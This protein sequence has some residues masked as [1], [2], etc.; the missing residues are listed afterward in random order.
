MC[1]IQKLSPE[2]WKISMLYQHVCSLTNNKL[3]CRLCLQSR[4]ETFVGSFIREFHSEEF[5]W[6]VS[7]FQSV[8]EHRCS[9]LVRWV[10][11]DMTVFTGPPHMDKSGVQVGSRPLQHLINDIWGRCN[12]TW[13]GDLITEHCHYEL[14]FTHRLRL[15]WGRNIWLIFL[16]W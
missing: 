15:G 3:N 4:N 11:I 5:Q 8:D 2:W 13:Q 10:L 9:S 1:C 12:V 14:W 7:L 6:S 16:L